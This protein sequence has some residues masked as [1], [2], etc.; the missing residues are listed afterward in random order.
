MEDE[1]EF[2]GNWV[3][4]SIVFGGVKSHGGVEERI[5]VTFRYIP[6]SVRS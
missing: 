2:I 3:R 6:V 4:A 5:R 1:V